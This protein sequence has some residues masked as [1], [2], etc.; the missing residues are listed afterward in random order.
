MIIFEVF[1]QTTALLHRRE[2]VTYGAHKRQ[3]DLDDE[4]VKDLKYNLIKAL[5]AFAIRVLSPLDER[6]KTVQPQ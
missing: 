1:D 6:G 4:C 3:F 5:P 2:P